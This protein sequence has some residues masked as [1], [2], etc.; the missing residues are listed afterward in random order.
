MDETSTKGGPLLQ[1]TAVLMMGHT[2]NCNVANQAFFYLTRFTLD[3]W[4]AKM[5]NP[6]DVKYP[7]PST[8]RE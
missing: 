5:M 4:E 7:R 6:H 2:C 3:T 8:G 1:I